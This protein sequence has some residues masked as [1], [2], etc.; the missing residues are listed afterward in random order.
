[1]RCPW[2]ANPEGMDA[3]RV[4]SDIRTLSIDELSLEI[5]SAKAMFFD[6][7]GVTFTGGEATLQMEA[8]L[9]LAK[10]LSSE[11][12]GVVLETNATHPRLEALFPYLQLLIADLKQADGSKLETVTGMK[13]DPVYRNLKK[14]AESGVP[15]LV[16]IPVIHG[17]NDSDEDIAAF[18]AFLSELASIRP[19][20]QL[21]VELLPYHEYGKV[22][23]EAFGMTYTMENAFVTPR[24]IACFE[25]T[26]QNHGITIIHT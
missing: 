16:R 12:I 11:G 1:M 23:W 17:F 14:A 22:K 5:H 10:A 25:E 15:L 6:D 20:G 8:L 19:N 4:G 24:R 21:D 7:G 13:G 18:A 3:G 2:C 26:L 9:P